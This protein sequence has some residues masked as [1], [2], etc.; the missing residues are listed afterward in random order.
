MIGV[1]AWVFYA[2]MVSMGRQM[3]QQLAASLNSRVNVYLDHLF[4]EPVT[5]VNEIHRLY[6]AGQLNQRSEE[7]QAR[8]FATIMSSQPEL[9]AINLG[10][11]DGRL[12]GVNRSLAN[13][14]L[15]TSVIPKGTQPY[16]EIYSVSENGQRDLFV[17]KEPIPYVPSKRLWYRHAIDQG[18]ASWYPIYRFAQGETADLIGNFAIG[19]SMPLFDEQHQPIG[20]INSDI[21]LGQISRYLKLLPL[22]EGGVAF[23]INEQNQIIGIS[24]DTPLF[25]KQ[26]T[27]GDE[28]NLQLVHF[29]NI[30][31][32]VVEAAG[33]RLPQGDAQ[34]T[35][36]KVN[37]ASYLESVHSFKT[38]QGLVLRVVILLPEKQF[39]PTLKANMQT[40]L[41]F[42]A[43]TL[44]LGIMLVLFAAHKLSKPIEQMTQWADQLAKG[45]W[46]LPSS[47]ND[48]EKLH[49]Y[50]IK[51]IRQ[52][53]NSLSTMAS[54]LNE[55]VATLEQRVAERTAELELVNSNLSELSNTDG[56]TGIP[57]RRKFDA[58]LASE[59]NRATR[60]GQ[61]LVLALID[62][63]WF[64]KF[65]D[66]YGHLAGDDCLRH[67]A[68]ILKAK[69]R[70]SSDLVARYGGEEFAI[71][72]PSINKANAI[73]MAN[74][75]CKTLAASAVPHAMSPFGV[76]TASIGVA[77][78]VPT[79][80]I[81]PA[82]LIQAADEA[83]YHAKDSGR[84]QVVFADIKIAP[85]DQFFESD[86]RFE[87]S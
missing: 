79:L 74:I 15:H 35:Y 58:V 24:N 5:S 4:L 39:F 85:E 16:R 86:I 47:D 1:W 53:R 55:T 66:H 63:D 11:E 68:T 45:N 80:D 48:P 31:S 2:N 64:K 49:D 40:M 54:S 29:N 87:Q 25:R 44:I 26:N 60:T 20:V 41:L 37:D 43:G 61:P 22:G 56:M 42:V 59:W 34:E 19:Y 12:I 8:Q 3:E 21:A 36:I 73:E 38:D 9:S 57:N 33:E 30:N 76:L 78:I 70:R 77:L 62:V 82:T 17:F 23:I 28:A 52:L 71:I 75:I 72:A 18:K 10:L 69:I 6:R 7:E 50:P 67:V 65:N 14:V 51:E 27:S 83:L 32:P 46:A 84:N 13:G 81:E